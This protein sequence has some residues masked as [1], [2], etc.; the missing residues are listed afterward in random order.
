MEVFVRIWLYSD[1]NQLDQVNRLLANHIDG[2]KSWIN[3]KATWTVEP[4]PR[5]LQDSM[6][7]EP[8]IPKAAREAAASPPKENM[9]FSS[10]MV[11]EYSTPR[12][13][14]NQD[15]LTQT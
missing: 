9:V 3:N 7:P 5:S 10:V 14:D 15:L 4:V 2:R 11:S 1:P 12:L 6:I 8:E 13:L